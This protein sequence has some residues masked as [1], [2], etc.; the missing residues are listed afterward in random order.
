MV[1]GRALDWLPA[2]VSLSPP[3]LSRLCTRSRFSFFTFFFVFLILLHCRELRM[4]YLCLPFDS[5]S[6]WAAADDG[7]AYIHIASLV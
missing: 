1:T 6:I 5:I 3:L 2:I 4:R 7:T